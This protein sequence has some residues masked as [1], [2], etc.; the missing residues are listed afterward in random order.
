MSRSR[1]KIMLLLAHE[2][3]SSEARLPDLQKGYGGVAEVA[4]RQRT[5]RITVHQM[6]SP[7]RLENHELDQQQFEAAD[8][9]LE[10]ARRLS[11]RRAA[12]YV[13]RRR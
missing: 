11:Q 6:R 1:Y 5:A 4:A 8:C 2:T 7:D 10:H 13:R 9:F 3:T 12:E